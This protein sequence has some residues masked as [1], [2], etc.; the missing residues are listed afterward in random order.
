M[1]YP[2]CHAFTQ[3]N[4]RDGYDLVIGLSTGDGRPHVPSNLPD[5]NPALRTV[6]EGLFTSADHRSLPVSLGIILWQL[7]TSCMHACAVV[8]ASVHQQLMASASNTKVVG[9][10]RFNIDSEVDSTR[11]VGAEWV[12]QRN[13][14]FFI[15]GH[16]SG[17]VYLYNK[18]SS[19]M[20]TLWHPH[21]RA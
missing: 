4:P 18:V 14:Q 6:A 16:L 19:A 10:L 8:V 7:L 20:L 12:P 2:T 13:G 11:V 9:M 15:V 5:H 3:V 17:K 1:I 21:L